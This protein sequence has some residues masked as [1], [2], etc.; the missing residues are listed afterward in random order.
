[1]NMTEREKELE[2]I[3]Y[4]LIVDHFWKTELEWVY[5]DDQTLFGVD[6]DLYLRI[7]A[8]IPEAIKAH[9]GER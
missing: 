8:V 5:N 4:S 7:A 2:S 1:M 9:E 3:L 6:L